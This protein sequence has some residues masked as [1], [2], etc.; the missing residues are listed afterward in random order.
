MIIIET[1]FHITFSCLN[2]NPQYACTGKCKKSWWQ[3]DFD[4]KLSMGL[5]PQCQS[6][7]TTAVEGVQFKV[8][9][10]NIR[11]MEIND[12]KEFSKMKNE[13]IKNLNEMLKSGKKITHLS[14]VKEDFFEK[15][16]TGWA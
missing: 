14:K 9:K 12:L 3:Y 15:A 6:G 5:C 7:L 11:N 8:L 4:K 10:R 16:L 13:E 1:P 2:E